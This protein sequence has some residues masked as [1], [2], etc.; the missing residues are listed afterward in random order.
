MLSSLCRCASARL[1][2]GTALLTRFA[3]EDALHEATV[4]GSVTSESNYSHF[5][6]QPTATSIQSS[7]TQELIH[8]AGKSRAENM[9]SC[10]TCLRKGVLELIT[11]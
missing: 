4:E 6:H 9:L 10:W 5:K 11:A 8:R 7:Y 1:E 2:K 3:T